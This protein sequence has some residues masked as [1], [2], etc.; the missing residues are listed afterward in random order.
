MLNLTCPDFDVI[1]HSAVEK[2]GGKKGKDGIRGILKKDTD[3]FNLQ[4][5]RKSIEWN[6][7]GGHLTGDV[8]PCES[9][10][11]FCAQTLEAKSHPH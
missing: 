4:A 5:E 7:S 3:M 6:L 10:V 11:T 1:T 2:L 8:C 9:A